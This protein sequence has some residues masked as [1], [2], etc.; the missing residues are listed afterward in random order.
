MAEIVYWAP[1]VGL[2]GMIALAFRI[3]REM[4]A[5][6]YL[7]RDL[8]EITAKVQR[9]A[10]IIIKSNSIVSEAIALKQYGAE[11]EAAEMLRQL[12]EVRR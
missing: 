3:E 10:E 5:L 7:R 2:V 1:L 4:I 11:D 12:S 6:L 8:A 9:E